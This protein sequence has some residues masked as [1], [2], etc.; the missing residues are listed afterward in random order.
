M[1]SG[2]CH[3]TLATGRVL[4]RQSAAIDVIQHGFAGCAQTHHRRWVD[5]QPAIVT[6]GVDHDAELENQVLAPG[7]GI[8]RE[9]RHIREQARDGEGVFGSSLG[10][11]SPR[12]DVLPLRKRDDVGRLFPVETLPGI[13]LVGAVDRGPAGGDGILRLHRDIAT[14]QG[15]VFA[16]DGEGLHGTIPR[17]CEVS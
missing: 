8:A 4:L 10:S 12:I 15:R 16:L 7:R 1:S 11:L 3:T 9:L 13:R 17:R 5:P 14:I 2:G 6:D